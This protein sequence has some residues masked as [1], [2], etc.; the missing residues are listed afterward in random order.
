[1]KVTFPHFRHFIGEF[2][3]K[4][5]TLPVWMEMARGWEITDKIPVSPELAILLS[6]IPGDQTGQGAALQFI[7]TK[8]VYQASLGREMIANKASELLGREVFDHEVWS[9]TAWKETKARDEEHTKTSQYGPLN[10]EKIWNMF[11][12]EYEEEYEPKEIP[13]GGGGRYVLIEALNKELVKHGFKPFHFGGP[14][15]YIEY[16]EDGGWA[17][18]QITQSH[19][20]PSWE[21]DEGARHVRNGID[22]SSPRFQ[23]YEGQKGKHMY[24]FAHYIPQQGHTHY[25]RVVDHISKLSQPHIEKMMSDK[26]HRPGGTGSYGGDFSGWLAKSVEKAKDINPFPNNPP[27]A[28]AFPEDEDILA[29]WIQILNAGIEKKGEELKWGPAEIAQVQERIFRRRGSEGFDGRYKNP[30]RK[31]HHVLPTRAIF[32]LGLE[33]RPDLAQK[34][35]NAYYTTKVDH[36]KYVGTQEYKEEP[37][38]LEHLASQGF[39]VSQG[40]GSILDPAVQAKGYMTIRRGEVG[41]AAGRETLKLHRD[42]KGQWYM[43]VPQ[44]TK[45]GKTKGKPPRMLLPM[46]TMQQ[47]GTLTHAPVDPLKADQIQANWEADA[48]AY[49]DEWHHSKVGGS[50]LKSVWDAAHS[51]VNKAV[52]KLGSGPEVRREVLDLIGGEPRGAIGYA[53][54]A[55]KGLMG[56]YKFKFGEPDKVVS[57]TPG[58]STEDGEQKEDTSPIF[59]IMKEGGISQPEAQGYIDKFMAKIHAG[60]MPTEKE[61]P[62]GVWKGFLKNGF[63]WRKYTAAEAVG[64]ELVRL[65]KV[66]R[67]EKSAVGTTGGDG[68][69]TDL[70]SGDLGRGQAKE[71]IAR[72][73]GFADR[74]VHLQDRR[75]AERKDVQTTAA[76]IGSA[77]Q[78]GAADMKMSPFR[79]ARIPQFGKEI[80]Q[81]DYES[82]YSMAHKVAIEHLSSFRRLAQSTPEPVRTSDHEENAIQGQKYRST[83]FA[84]LEDM[85]RMIDGARDK[86]PAQKKGVVDAICDAIG[87][88]IITHFEDLPKVGSEGYDT[89]GWGAYTMLLYHAFLTDNPKYDLDAIAKGIGVD[90]IGATLQSLKTTLHA[91]EKELDAANEPTIHPHF[92][93]EA[94]KRRSEELLDDEIM[95]Q[96]AQVSAATPVK[97][98]VSYGGSGAEEPEDTIFPMK[99]K[100]AAPA[101]A[102][103]PAK[104]VSGMAARML[105]KARERAA[106]QAA[107]SQQPLRPTGT[108]GPTTEGSMI[109]FRDWRNQRLKETAGGPVGTKGEGLP[110]KDKWTFNVW[111][112]VGN[113]GGTTIKGEVPVKRSVKGKKK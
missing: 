22:M 83:I 61:F 49:G 74:N 47:A 28:I 68:Q 25:Q 31:D 11:K 1:M 45:V 76:V 19:M 10:L 65:V 71:R 16:L 24:T 36:K 73:G 34:L 60:G 27:E 96:S 40:G 103:Q 53:Q 72:R 3:S 109:S 86:E 92:H 102:A 112:A 100:V 69:T 85:K 42:E 67:R 75:N 66:G 14:N 111:G 5:R 44:G 55:M 98:H 70:V 95:R 13:T 18:R 12:N 26:E 43:L 94:M 57:T 80:Q 113:P 63:Y 39:V 8:G 104:P 88:S 93:G 54:E 46:G 30:H 4:Y 20:K 50:V 108:D 82:G 7:Q 105:A 23:E 81:A 17:E 79:K 77:K 59:V 29:I 87:N 91:K 33:E 84:P 48:E 64:R 15:G 107:Q 99:P 89:K 56:T 90:D 52:V 101:Q 38:N 78:V 62:E 41:S 106:Q 97:Q 6:F 21:G 37:A 35:Q 51:G 9:E 58:G 110:P 32:E 2:M